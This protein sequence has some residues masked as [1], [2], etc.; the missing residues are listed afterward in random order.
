[1]KC[2]NNPSL[3]EINNEIFCYSCYSLYPK[4]INYNN[5]II[6]RS[7]VNNNRL[8]YLRK[9]FSYLHNNIILFLNESIEEIKNYKNSKKISNTIYINSL[10]KYYTDRSNIIYKPLVDKE[11]Y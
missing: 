2:C 3:E 9:N 4:V 10:Y 1:M 7:P 11:N 5:K 8:K 6:K